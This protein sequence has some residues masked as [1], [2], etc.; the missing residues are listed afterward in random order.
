MVKYSKYQQETF[1]VL[2][3]ILTVTQLGGVCSITK[4]LMK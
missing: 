2:N 3:L 4:N 1:S